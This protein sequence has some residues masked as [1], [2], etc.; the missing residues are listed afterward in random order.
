MRQAISEKTRRLVAER[1]N[2]RCEYCQIHSDDLFLSFEIDHIIPLKHGGSHA[3]GNLAFACPHCNQHKGSDFATLFG[4]EIVRLFNPRTDPWLTHF[5]SRNGEILPK[6][7]VGEAS[8]KILRF[9]QPD[10]LIL[11]Q[12]LSQAGRYP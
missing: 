3:I 4:D 5:E 10:Q 6:T 8:A 1:A 7:R 12:I 11:R 2:F 9:N